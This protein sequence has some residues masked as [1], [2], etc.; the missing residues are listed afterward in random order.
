LLLQY[1]SG[2]VY[3][4]KGFNKNQNHPMQ[5]IYT[6]LTV[7]LFSFS[8]TAQ[9]IGIGTNTPNSNAM[10]D[11]QS[12]NKGVLVPRMDSV[13]RKN[14]PGTKGLLVYDSTYQSFWYNNGTAWQRIAA[15]AANT[16]AYWCP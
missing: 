9:N 5:K 8:V 6:L 15:G 1:F 10:L 16:S 4:I 7:L 12:S 3:S 11:I 2:S 14:I 13:Q